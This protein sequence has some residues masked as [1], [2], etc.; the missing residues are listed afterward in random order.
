MPIK[1]A[2]STA[3]K[4]VEK[5]AP[6]KITKTAATKAKASPKKVVNQSKQKK[7]VERGS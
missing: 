4:V 5:K 3:K 2:S 7:K 1:R 6:K